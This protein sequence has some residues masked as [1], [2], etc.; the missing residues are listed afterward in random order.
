MAKRRV[1]V[2]GLGIVSPVG[3]NLNES[4]ESI[5]NGKSG[6]ASITEFDTEKFSVKFAC[7]VKNFDSESY[8]SR[9][10]LK[11]MDTFIHY[12]IAAADQ[13]LNDS[14]L[15]IT[16]ENAERIGVAIGSGIGGLPIIEKNKEALDAGGPRKISPFLIP[17]SIINMI[18]GNV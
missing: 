5:I 16:D 1:V 12:G 7:T 8:V 18:S 13:A 6:A 15:E 9:K 17:G 10:E 4:W 2:T 3:L 11:K 14:G